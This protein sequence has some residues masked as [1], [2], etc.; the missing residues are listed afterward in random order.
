MR[1]LA[2]MC[3]LGCQLSPSC[4]PG[5]VLQIL[6]TF[7]DH[8]RAVM[9]VT[10]LVMSLLVERLWQTLPTSPYFVSLDSL[11]LTAAIMVFGGVI[12]FVMVWTEFSVIQQTSALTFMVAGTFKEIV[13]GAIWRWP[14]PGSLSAGL[15]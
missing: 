6:L 9:S 12:A 5:S 3:S 11:G 8:M 7:A 10:V 13:T 2:D 14:T 1:T 15:L 4:C